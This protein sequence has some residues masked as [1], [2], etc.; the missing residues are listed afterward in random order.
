MPLYAGSG[1]TP[2]ALRAPVRAPIFCITSASIT[3]SASISAM[4]GKRSSDPVAIAI[5]DGRARLE[6][7]EALQLEPLLRFQFGNRRNDWL[8]R[9]SN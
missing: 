1:P 9:R 2:V 7:H 3:K 6:L 8:R 5:N 4:A